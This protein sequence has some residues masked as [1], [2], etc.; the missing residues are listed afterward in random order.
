MKILKINIRKEATR[1]NEKRKHPTA[2]QYSR[3]YKIRSSRE[4]EIGHI[5]RMRESRPT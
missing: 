2:V 4:E 5:S 3:H 1:V